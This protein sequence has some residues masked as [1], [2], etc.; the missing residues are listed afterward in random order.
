VHKRKRDHLRFFGFLVNNFAG[1]PC[2]PPKGPDL[3]NPKVAH[4]SGN[5]QTTRLS[6]SLLLRCPAI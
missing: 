2:W 1:S 6:H 3:T 5:G 4:S